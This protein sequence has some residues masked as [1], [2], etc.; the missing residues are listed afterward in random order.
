MNEA[1]QIIVVMDNSV[2]AVPLK[3][4]EKHMRRSF[5]HLTVG[6]LGKNSFLGVICISEG[7]TSKLV[8]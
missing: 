1:N 6:E 4:N 3:H 5:L 7:Q 8:E 2:S